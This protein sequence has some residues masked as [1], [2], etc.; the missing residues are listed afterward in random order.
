[1]ASPAVA[2]H[3][4]TARVIGDVRGWLSESW[5]VVLVTE[6][7]G[8]AQ[9]LA[10]LLRN[11]ELGAR[12]GDLDSP[13]EPSV[14]VVATGELDA[15]FVWPQVKLA[16]L[17]ESD[18]AGQRAGQRDRSRMPSRRRGGIDPLRLR[19]RCPAR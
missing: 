15:G 8:P 18:L 19:S 12:T 7:H 6:G 10:E 4:D 17:S 5:R 16:V 11:A 13:P 3:G 2:Y 9:R 14:A 1:M